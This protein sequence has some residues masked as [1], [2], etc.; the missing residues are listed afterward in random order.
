MSH[1]KQAIVFKAEIPN[2]IQTLTGH[3][4]EHTFLEMGQAQAN[5]AGFVPI[6]DE[7]DLVAPFHGGLAFRV[8][9]DEKIVPASVVKAETEKAVAEISEETGR[10]PGKKERAQIREGVLYDLICRALSKTVASITC[11]YHFESGYLIVPTTNKHL[12]DI[13]VSQLIKAVG[14]VKTETIHVS[15]VKHGLTTRLLKWLKD[16]HDAFG[17]FHPCDEAALVGDESRKLTVKMSTLDTAKEGL[18]EVLTKGFKVN[19]LGFH[20]NGSDFRLSHDFRLRGIKVHSVVDDEEMTW[21][22]AI[23]L[24]V[25]AVR[26][27]V[28]ELCTMLSYKEEDDQQGGAA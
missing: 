9:Y 10:K 18:I 5:S 20:H 27:I 3:L 22:S 14:S 6:S 7:H 17:E 23:T 21:E 25:D 12:A 28:S 16:D 4:K 26:S 13:C 19:S 11:F 8:R 2:S 15:D 1:I 24:Q